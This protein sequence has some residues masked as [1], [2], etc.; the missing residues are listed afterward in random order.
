MLFEVLVLDWL[1]LVVVI[2]VLTVW[3]AAIECQ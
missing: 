1:G 2:W 3:D